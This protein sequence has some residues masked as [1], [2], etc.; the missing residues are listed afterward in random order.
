MQQHL[1]ILL[2]LGVG[3]KVAFWAGGDTNSEVDLWPQSS[4]CWSFSRLIFVSA[5]ITNPLSS[6][7]LHS[8]LLYFQILSI[9]ST[10]TS[11]Y[12]WHCL[13]IESWLD[14]IAYVARNECTRTPCS[15]IHL[16]AI[17][18]SHGNGIFGIWLSSLLSIGR[19]CCGLI[20]NAVIMHVSLIMIDP[21]SRASQ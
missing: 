15:L 13:G 21:S 1:Q 20:A 19:I 8:S 11:K 17:L 18:D 16:F 14:Y 4:G 12:L 9:D 2:C 6:T 3:V 7:N 5:G 10:L